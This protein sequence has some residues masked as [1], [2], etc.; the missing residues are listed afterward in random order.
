MD[1]HIILTRFNQILN[2][3]F[4]P[5]NMYEGEDSWMAHRLRLFEKYTLK[6]WL[7]QS[8]Q[9]YHLFLLCDPDT[10]DQYKKILDSYEDLGI[11]LK[12]LYTNEAWNSPKFLSSLK[13]LYLK[14]R[15][16][17]SPDIIISR[18]D[19]DD[20]ISIHY[21]L[22]IKQAT[23]TTPSINLSS[24]MTY[25]LSTQK[26]NLFTFYASPF[27]SVK[28]KLEEFSTPF[29]KN[30]VDMETVPI[31]YDYPLWCWVIHDRNANNSMK[32]SPIENFTIEM[33]T[34]LFGYE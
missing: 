8:D 1:N 29:T 14:L 34:S 19:N 28:S 23:Q 25:D 11:N 6:S 10:P 3:S 9:Q 16:N 2:V 4:S 18:C 27:V 15:T 24:G 17:T 32:G 31:I 20:L 5:S 21:N 33:L 12:I 22:A 30:H 13:E 26:A 7:S